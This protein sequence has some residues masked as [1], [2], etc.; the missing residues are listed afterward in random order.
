MTAKIRQFVD[1]QVFV[2]APVN[3]KTLLYIDEV[4]TG[5]L[6]RQRVVSDDRYGGLLA[7]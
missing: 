6:A 7:P 3:S 1:F 4:Q 5:A 2:F